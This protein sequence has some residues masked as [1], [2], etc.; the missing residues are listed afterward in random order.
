MSNQSWG[1]VHFN[2]LSREVYG[3]LFW[4]VNV[5]NN[6]A[7]QAPII[8]ISWY[9]MRGD[10]SEIA[11]NQWTDF[12][13]WT[14]L[15]HP[16]WTSD[17]LILTSSLLLFTGIVHRTSTTS[18][19]CFYWLI[20]MIQPTVFSQKEKIPRDIVFAFEVAG[21][22]QINSVFACKKNQKDRIWELTHN[23]RCIF[24]RST[25][26]YFQFHHPVL[27]PGYNFTVYVQPHCSYSVDFF[28]PQLAADFSKTTPEAHW[29]RPAD[30]HLVNTLGHLAASESDITLW[31][32]K[33]LKLELK[34]NEYS[35]HTRQLVERHG[36]K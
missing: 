5:A 13:C 19:H 16:F 20:Y 26:F 24:W 14:F 28:L 8:K 17:C 36:S 33:K 3:F 11:R 34:L 29:P 12:L 31:S 15:I 27:L 22:I 7:S 35:N 6:R 25:V 1:C 23:C 2:A 9:F 10:K 4:H 32:W 18:N 21:F 30:R